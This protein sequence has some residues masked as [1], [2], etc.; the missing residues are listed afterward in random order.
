[1]CK[2]TGHGVWAESLRGRSEGSVFPLAQ[3]TRTVLSRSAQQAFVRPLGVH[4]MCRYPITCMVSVLHYL[5]TLNII[6]PAIKVLFR[7]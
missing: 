7:L 4:F 1:M 5:L 3:E 2:Y 6:V